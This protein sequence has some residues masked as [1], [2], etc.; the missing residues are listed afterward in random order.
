MSVVTSNIVP[1]RSTVVY[2]DA[3]DR[4]SMSVHRLCRAL[5]MLADSMGMIFQESEHGGIRVYTSV[6]LTSIAPPRQADTGQ[7]LAKTADII[8]SL[9]V[10]NTI[11]TPETTL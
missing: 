1:Q 5:K 10:I 7:K 2:G 4:A 9:I 11:S 6:E 8:F 3:M